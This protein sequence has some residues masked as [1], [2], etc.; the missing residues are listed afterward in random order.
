MTR[1][2]TSHTTYH[3]RCRH[4]RAFSLIE[5]L[6]A[7]AILAMTI[8][9]LSQAVT[10][11]IRGLEAV[12]SDSEREQLYRFALRQ[13]LL[14]EDREEIERGGDFSTPDGASITWNADIQE[15]EVLDLFLLNV[16]LILPDTTSHSLFQRQPGH[17]EN[18]YVFRPDWSDPVDRSSLRTDKKDALDNERLRAR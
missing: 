4:H 11:G 16:T 1:P 9:V 15:T 3:T 17:I 7:L 2:D 6:V 13:V 5:V 18:V 14:I 8:G 10:N 12:Q